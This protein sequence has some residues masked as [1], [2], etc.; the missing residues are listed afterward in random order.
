MLDMD[1]LLRSRRDS[2]FDM[3]V[4]GPGTGPVHSLIDFST[5]ELLDFT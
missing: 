1:S 4:L 3:Q 2:D 5:R